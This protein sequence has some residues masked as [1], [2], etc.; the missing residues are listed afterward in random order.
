MISDGTSVFS[1]IHYDDFPTLFKIAADV[2][3]TAI[4]QAPPAI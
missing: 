3:K 2:L 1:S 4:I